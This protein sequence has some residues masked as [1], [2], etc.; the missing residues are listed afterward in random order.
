MS[1]APC[2]SGMLHPPPLVKTGNTVRC[3]VSFASRVVVKPTP[4]R[5]ALP[6]SSATMVLPRR[7]PCWS[8]NERRM[9]PRPRSATSFATALA[10][11]CCSGV[12]RPCL[13]TKLSTLPPVPGSGPVSS[14]RRFQRRRRPGRVAALARIHVAPVCLPLRRRGNAVDGDG[15]AD[16]PRR[17]RV[18][19]H[20]GFLAAVL[21]LLDRLQQHRAVI[22]DG[23]VGAAE[24]LAG[25]V[26]D[27]P[28]AFDRPLVMHVD[29]VAHAGIGAGFLLQRIE[30]V[31]VRLV[32]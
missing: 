23:L 28:L 11:F 26:L 24:M 19:H 30:A 25:A 13:S 21:D 3:E 12:Q 7:M 22:D 31:I 32:Q 18:Q 14:F 27:R 9:T 2:I 4:L 10:C 1:A 16:P 17:R 15:T 5:M 6:S 8:A 29:V 20:Q